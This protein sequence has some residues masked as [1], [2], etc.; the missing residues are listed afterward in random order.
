M[1]TGVILSMYGQIRL[2]AVLVLFG[3]AAGVVYDLFRAV[4]RIFYHSVLAVQIE[5]LLFWLAFTM[6]VMLVMLWENNAA[7]RFFS[8]AAPLLGML[9][10]FCTLSR[11]F[12]PP[13]VLVLSA[14][15]KLIR[16]ILHIFCTP[17][18]IAGKIMTVLTK[19]L[20]KNLIIFNKIAKKLL[21]NSLKC[22]TI[23]E[24]WLHKSVCH[25]NTSGSDK[26]E[27]RSQ[28]KKKK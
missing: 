24:K 18:V 8:I 28:E 25:T 22:E 2:F 9:F 27:R 10:Y 6:A 3:M 21:K 14:V 7:L 19:K 26:V 15:I 20:E 13:M 17:L 1:M 23:L 16:I 4:R 12:M 5:D 11:C